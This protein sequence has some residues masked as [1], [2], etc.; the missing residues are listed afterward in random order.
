MPRNKCLFA[1]VICFCLTSFSWTQAKQLIPDLRGTISEQNVYANPAL[2]MTINLP[3]EWRLLDETS[4]TPNDPSCTGPLCGAPNINVVL[5]SKPGSDSGYRLYLSGWKL[6]TQ[7]LNRSRYPLEWFAGIMLEGS[8]GHDLVPLEKHKALQL[9]GRPA[10]RLL[11]VDRGGRTPKVIGYVSEVRGYV[12]LLVCA[13][14]IKPEVM[15]SAIEGMKLQKSR[16]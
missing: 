2:G 14:P 4:E 7:Y 11:M 8:M 10:F 6:S 3:G 1:I 16:C 9:D 13:T 12:L 5:E 15:Q